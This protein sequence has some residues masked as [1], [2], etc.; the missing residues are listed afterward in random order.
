M[1]KTETALFALGCFWEPDIYFASLPGVISTEVG[2]SGGTTPDPNYTDLGDHTETVKVKFDPSS[3]S[4]EEL[5]KHF[6][7]RHNPTFTHKT[8]YRSAIFTHNDEQMHIA[9]SSKLNEEK[10]RGEKFATS[11]EP[12]GAFYRAEEYHQKYLEKHG[13]AFC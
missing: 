4:Y 9:Q 1:A 8:Q 5:L 7:N 11:I 13:A 10:K 3:I 12:A 6:W 2:Y